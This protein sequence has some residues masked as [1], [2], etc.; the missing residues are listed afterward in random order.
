[1]VG[2]ELEADKPEN[3]LAHYVFSFQTD[4]TKFVKKVV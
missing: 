4:K 2:N 1:M 3:Y